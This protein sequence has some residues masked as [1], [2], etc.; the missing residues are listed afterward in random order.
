MKDFPGRSLT[1]WVRQYHQGVLAI[2]E[3]VGKVM[4]AL[5]A[6]GQDRNTV[7]VFTSDQGFAWGQHGMKSKVAPHDAAVAA[8][9]IIR[10]A[11]NPIDTISKKFR[12]HTIVSFGGKCLNLPFP[13]DHQAQRRGLHSPCR[14]SLASEV[15]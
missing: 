2:D 13:V 15:R 5:K 12:L 11:G 4:Q 14:K 7:V 6:S 8:P 3:G 9:L 10:P 1:D